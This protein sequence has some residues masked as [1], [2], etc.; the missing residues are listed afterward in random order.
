MGTLI[1]NQ[2][3]DTRQQ[4]AHVDGERVADRRKLVHRH[5]AGGSDDLGKLRL[6]HVAEHCKLCLAYVVSG[7]L[8]AQSGRNLLGDVGRSVVVHDLIVSDLTRN[9]QGCLHFSSCELS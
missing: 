5:W 9:A 2:G 1:V 3:L 8:T 7:D 4:F 6:A